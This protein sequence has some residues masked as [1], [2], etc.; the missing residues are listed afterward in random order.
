[1]RSIVDNANIALDEAAKGQLQA[2]IDA[3]QAQLQDFTETMRSEALT[4][5]SVRLLGHVGGF[6]GAKPGA[7]SRGARDLRR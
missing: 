3:K 5:A 7:V 2:L 1:M 6:D 4:F